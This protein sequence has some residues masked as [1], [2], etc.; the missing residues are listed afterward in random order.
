MTRGDDKAA[1][2]SGERGEARSYGR[3]VESESGAYTNRFTGDD[4]IRGSGVGPPPEPNTVTTPGPK[5]DDSLP[6][7]GWERY[8]VGDT[9]GVGGM[10]RVVEAW[11]P[12]LQRT[13]A[14]KFLRSDDP[15]QVQRFFREAQAQAKVEHEHVC[16]V[17]EVGQVEGHPF[18]AMQLLRG[19]PLNDVAPQ[20]SLEQ[21]TIVIRKVAEAVHAAHR[22]GLIHRDLKPANIMVEED[23]GGGWH[24]YVVD[25]GLA[26]EVAEE[27]LTTTGC[28]VG[29]PAY[30]APEQVLGKSTALDRRTDVY[31]L[32]A[33]LYE[34]V[35]GRKMFSGETPMHVMMQILDEEPVRPRKAEPSCPVD[36]ETVILKC[37][38]KEPHRRYDSA[39]ALADDLQRFLEG[40]PVRA[41]RGGRL[42][43]AGKRIRRHR[44]LAAVIVAAAV[45]TLAAGGFG[46]R[47]SWEA[48]KRAVIAQRFGQQVK[49]MESI[50]R[51]AHMMPLHDTSREEAMVRE[52]MGRLGVEM[53]RLGAISR[54]PGS[55]ALGIASLA[56]R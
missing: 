42:H 29:T 54:G 34:A 10:G 52:R 53:D 26:R 25:F 23:D 5:G 33:T 28:L 1:A 50:M 7:A 14:L 36:I 48:R 19:S 47:A 15:E 24:P 11:D 31:A 40:E 43:R 4:D 21:K 6:G 51:H 38:E 20:L 44:T 27:G 17:Y 18:I 16:K 3:E 35:T 46:L 8:V 32:G 30:M 2:D 13:V 45:F 37:I 55:Y 22:L 56:L 39:R 12:R 41:R 49:E 9:I